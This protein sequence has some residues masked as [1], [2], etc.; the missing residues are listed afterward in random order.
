MLSILIP[1]YNFDCLLLIQG[2]HQQCEELNGKD[3]HFSYEIIVV[4]DASTNTEIVERL[5]TGISQMRG[6]RFI[7]LLENSRHAAVRNRLLKEA[8]GNW[9][10][11][12][13]SDAE[14]VKDDFVAT[15]WNKRNSASIVVGGIVHSN[16]VKSGC[17]LRIAYEASV[18]YKRDVKW[19]NAH[20]YAI[21]S[22]FNLMALKSAITPYGFDERCTE[23]GYEDFL[24]GMA[25]ERDSVS[26]SHIENPLLHTGIDPSSVF[27]R[28]SETAMQTLS[29]LPKE[30][31]NKIGIARVARNLS[32]VGGAFVFKAVFAPFENLVRN[33]L[34]G[35]NPSIFLFQLYKLNY[36]LKVQTEG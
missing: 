8:R 18:A 30:L 26:I 27:L 23:Y 5:E 36:Y 20:P 11:M 1:T 2:L 16:A 33:N 3:S 29:K 25:L 28:K 4:D 22:V 13:D 14:I 19:R 32:R 35:A 21:F 24:L 17:E 34:L 9:V 10:L 15:Y 7:K 31:R 6:V 12:I